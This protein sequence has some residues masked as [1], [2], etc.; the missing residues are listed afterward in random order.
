[1][2]VATR[3]FGCLKEIF[4]MQ[5]PHQKVIQ[6]STM[7]GKCYTLQLQLMRKQ[8]VA[9]K[10]GSCNIHPKYHI[11]EQNA[12]ILV[13]KIKTHILPNTGH[14]NSALFISSLKGDLSFDSIEETSHINY[15]LLDALFFN[16]IY[17]RE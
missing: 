8:S 11:L 17:E 13:Y 7:V 16:C 1:M 10:K 3:E 12:L 2:Q 14:K 9:L 4:T 15:T 6:D 5:S